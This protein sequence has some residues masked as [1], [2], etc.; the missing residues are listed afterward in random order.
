LEGEITM[1]VMREILNKNF[2]LKVI[3]VI[4]ATLFWIVVFNVD[5]EF[6]DKKLVVPLEVV[7]AESLADKEIV[8]LSDIPQT[9]EITVRGRED[10][11]LDVTPDKFRVFV[12]LG[13]VQSAN[14]TKLTIE[15][16]VFD[17]KDVYVSKYNKQLDVKFERLTS[18][19]FPINIRT[20]GTPAE[21]YSV[22][23]IAQSPETV[24]LRGLESVIDS[25][26]GIET[27]IDLNG[28]NEDMSME[29]LCKVYDGKGSIIQ[30][31]GYLSV[32]DIKVTV[33]LKVGKTVNVTPVV[34]G[35]PAADYY[36]AGKNCAPGSV[37]VSGPADLLA[38]LQNVSTEP[39]SVEN[40]EATFKQKAA[41]VL[42]EGVKLVE[43]KDGVEVSV[44]IEQ[45]VE[46]EFRLTKNS[47]ELTRAYTDGSY[48][49]EVIDSSIVVKVKGRREDVDSLRPGDMR[50]IADVY[51]LQDGLHGIPPK[52]VMPDRYSLV[53]VDSITLKIER[54]RDVAI[55][56][57]DISVLNLNENYKYVILSRAIKPIFRGRLDILESLTA[58]TLKPAIDVRGIGAGVKT[59]P[60][61]VE[62]PAGVTLVQDIYIDIRVDEVMPQESETVETTEP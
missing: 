1:I 6:I 34:T 22:I 3:S 17:L 28:V 61:L 5:N 62:I 20:V 9:I 31:D 21:G 39:V 14:E 2:S 44:T 23:D 53:S 32:E 29:R 55:E 41:V 13:K 7:N 46:R 51:G 36:V 11:F 42:P 57:T 26:S 30:S 40:R 4:V 52:V 19:T 33:G 50:L 47:V 35:S 49:Y 43:P 54:F 45:M 12:D 16:P 56:N 18:K 24:E 58:Q 10:A 48:H 59:V 60:L 8:L 37:I 38:N 27:V 25:I 15:E